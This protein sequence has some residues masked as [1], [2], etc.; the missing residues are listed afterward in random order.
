M[1]ALYSEYGFDEAT[2]EQIAAVSNGCGG[3]GIGFLVPNTVFFQSV[4]ESC[5]RH[6]WGYHHGQT[7]QDKEKTD[8][9]FLNNMIRQIDAKKS[10]KWVKKL[11]YGRAYQNYEI[12]K[13]FGGPWF[14]KDK[15]DGPTEK[16]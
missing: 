14:W 9:A 13:K 5:Y 3:A 4:I 6:D 10:W 8:R 15:K 11:R 12:V 1:T 7:I 16:A 2:P